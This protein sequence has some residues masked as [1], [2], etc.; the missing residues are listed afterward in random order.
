MQTH[1][2]LLP[3]LRLQAGIEKQ[4]ENTA[5]KD[6]L[7]GAG[8]ALE[9]SRGKAGLD[10]PAA[11]AAAA[12]RPCIAAHPAGVLTL[13]HIHSAPSLIHQQLHPC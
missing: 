12:C 1:I 7:E 10:W 2:M 9:V 4:L 13:R 11:A 3:G 8:L 5:T 6:D